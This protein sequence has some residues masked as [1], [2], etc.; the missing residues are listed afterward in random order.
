MFR[1]TL[2]PVALALGVTLGGTSASFGA[3]TGSGP[4]PLVAVAQETVMDPESAQRELADLEQ[5]ETAAPELQNFQGG[6]TLI[7]TSS[8]LAIVVLVVVLIVIL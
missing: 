8:A 2:V 7:I 4:A 1:S 3:T 5:R 6:D